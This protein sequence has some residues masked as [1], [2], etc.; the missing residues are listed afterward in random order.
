M[1]AAAGRRCGGVPTLCEQGQSD[2]DD[3]N[4][5]DGQHLHAHI[6]GV[7]R[8]LATGGQ[9]VG[10]DDDEVV[11][12]QERDGGHGCDLEGPPVGRPCSQEDSGDGQ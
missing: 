9:A 5:G 12:G 6:G 2:E 4:E 11:E 1:W 3:A 7:V 8:V 10:Q